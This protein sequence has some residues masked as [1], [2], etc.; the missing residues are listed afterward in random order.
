MRRLV[1]ILAG[2]VVA[3]CPDKPALAP[4]GG[5]EPSDT[6]HLGAEGETCILGDRPVR[7]CAAGLACRPPTPRPVDPTSH[8]VLSPENA[9]CG[10]VGNVLC[11]GGLTCAWNEDESRLDQTAMGVCKKQWICELVGDGE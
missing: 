6:S 7:E 5:P 1:A 9:P 8:D 11:A 4:Q 10:G 2:L 3:G